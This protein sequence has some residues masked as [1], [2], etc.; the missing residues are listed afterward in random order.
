MKKLCICALMFCTFFLMACGN[1]GSMNVQS[2]ELEGIERLHID[3]GSTPVHIESAEVDAL[4]AF[5]SM[6]SYNSDIVMVQKNKELK[7]QLKSDLTRIINIGRKPWLTIRVP[8][9]YEGE[10]LLSGSSGN[11]K[12]NDLQADKLNID[13]KSGN[14]SMDYQQINQDI[15]VS[16]Y[17]GNVIL[18]LKDK[19]SNVK[20]LLK[21]GSGR[22][23]VAIPWDE[24]QDKQK[25]TEGLTGNGS[26]DVYIKT[27]SGNI[28]IRE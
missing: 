18:K 14:V 6:G 27:R 23:S 11:V 24:R 21:S 12:I 20:W 19:D 13:S 26:F 22:R 4:E 7:I 28:S 5:I 17:S 3:H 25:S 15:H 10:V 1:E 9:N 8:M 16:V 2:K